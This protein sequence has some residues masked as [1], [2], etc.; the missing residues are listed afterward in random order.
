MQIFIDPGDN[1]GKPDNATGT[2]FD[3]GNANQQTINSLLGF[4]IIVSILFKL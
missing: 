3:T 4:V 1:S 2:I